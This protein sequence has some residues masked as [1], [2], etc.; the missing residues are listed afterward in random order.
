MSLSVLTPIQIRT[1]RV[2]FYHRLKAVS[3]LRAMLTL[4][5]FGF[6]FFPGLFIT[7]KHILK[8]RFKKWKDSDVALVSERYVHKWPL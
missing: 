1:K 2:S 3:L 4:F 7:I 8:T 5:L 6:A